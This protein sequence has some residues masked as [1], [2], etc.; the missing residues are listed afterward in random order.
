VKA[1][2]L[3][4]AP[5][6]AIAHHGLADGARNRE[7]DVWAFSIRLPHTKSRE[8]RPSE[9]GPFLINPSEIFGSQQTDT[10]RKT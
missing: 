8:E 1:H 9:F 10:F 3:S 4:N 5:P 6:Y 2:S 7:A